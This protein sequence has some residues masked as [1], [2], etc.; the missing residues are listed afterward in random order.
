MNCHYYLLLYLIFCLALVVSFLHILRTDCFFL[1]FLCF[2]YIF[3]LCL[4]LISLFFNLAFFVCI[5]CCFV[6]VCIIFF[7]LTLSHA[8][9]CVI[10]LS[11]SKIFC[12]EFNFFSLSRAVST[13]IV[14]KFLNDLMSFSEV[15]FDWFNL[16]IYF[17]NYFDFFASSCCFLLTHY[18]SF[19]YCFVFLLLFYT[20]T[21]SFKLNLKVLSKF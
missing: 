4:L 13:L 18:N 17:C 20:G 7:S 3:C 16:F 10:P 14:V 11:L 6:L 1:D 9:V 8:M 19:P 15:C 21:E 5:S 2:F 12:R